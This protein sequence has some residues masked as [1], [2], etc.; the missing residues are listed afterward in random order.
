[1]FC[2]SH[3]NRYIWFYSD[4]ASTVEGTDKMSIP[5]KMMC[6]G[7]GILPALMLQDLSFG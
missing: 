2:G 4:L 5:H 7:V 1:M 6:C 3:K